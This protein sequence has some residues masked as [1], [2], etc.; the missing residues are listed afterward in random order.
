MERILEIPGISKAR[1]ISRINRFLVELDVGFAHL[2]DPG[3][4][5]ELLVPGREVAVKKVE[6][7]HRKTNL[8]MMAIKTRYWVFLN[9][10][11]HSKIAERIIPKIFGDI[12]GKEVKM[13][14]SRI[15]FL[16]ADGRPLEV[17]GCTLMEGRTALFPD[18]PTSRGTRHVMEI[19]KHKG[20]LLFLV[21]HPAM[22]LKPN[23]QT[24]PDFCNAV[25]IAKNS[26]VEIRAVRIGTQL[27]RDK[28]ILRYGGEIPVII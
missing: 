27:V 19:S 9:S 5:D 1:F 4:L 25:K 21:F 17:K 8:D 12:A 3:R 20:A 15:D 2:H 22:E 16:L 26:G 14:S 10:G 7:K 13:G 23:C 18:A 6:T 11:Y 28:L 24:D